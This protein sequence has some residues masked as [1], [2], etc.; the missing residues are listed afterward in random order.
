M[1][2]RYYGKH[3]ALLCVLGRTAEA[4]RVNAYNCSLC[5]QL[6]SNYHHHHQGNQASPIQEASMLCAQLTKPHKAFFT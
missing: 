2:Q 6:I 4:Q 3:Q 1:L 5:L